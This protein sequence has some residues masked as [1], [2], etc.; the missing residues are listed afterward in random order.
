[1]A[2]LVLRETVIGRA[3]RAVILENELLSATVLLDQGADIYSLVYKPLGVDV[4]W[5]SPCPAREPGVGPTPAGDSLAL[6]M[7][8]YRGGW[9]LAF[10]NFGPAIE[11]KG[12]TLPMHGEAARLPWELESAE[13]D[14]RGVRLALKV[15]LL[16]T[17]FRIR[18]VLT[19][20]ANEPALSLEETI[21]NQG[22][23]PLD[24]MWCHHPAFGPPLLSAGCYLDTGA[25]TVESDDSYDVPGNDL[26][27]GERWTW[28]HVQ[29]RQGRGIDLSRLPERDSGHSRVLFLK[30]L[31]A[32]WYALTNPA[33][34]LGVGL[35]WDCHVL[36]YACIWQETGGVR[37]YPW[38]GRAYVTA[39]EPT[40]SYPAAGLTA[41]M[42]KT[43]TQV[44][45]AP[46]Q[47]RT[48]SL[49]VVFYT[50]HSRVTHVGLD[51][52]VQRA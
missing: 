3:L 6:W 7:A 16:Q 42:E 20:Q 40:S 31:D 17:P 14:G 24:C 49:R 50:G 29:D 44:N 22:G 19:L 2:E 34:G 52:S 5:K 33:L 1:M 27:L 18:R 21:T 32:G 37:D 41:V 38:F 46:G 36:P 23:E 51:G 8:Y 11:Y 25:R 43:G 9:Q 48:L 30:D 39:V 45:F 12:A 47:S 28:P 4:L 13:S 15:D 26:P 35:A 10:P